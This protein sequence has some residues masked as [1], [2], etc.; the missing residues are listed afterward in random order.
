MIEKALQ[1]A[2]TVTFNIP[3]DK[4]ESMS[5][6]DLGKTAFKWDSNQRKLVP[7]SNKDK[8]EDDYMEF[9]ILF[10]NHDM[11]GQIL[12]ENDCMEDDWMEIDISFGTSLHA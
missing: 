9:G 1:R 12:L 7:K 11:A 10:G 3:Q 2:N 8:E 6:I 4:L 5:I